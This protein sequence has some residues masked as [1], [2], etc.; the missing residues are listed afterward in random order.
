MKTSFQKVKKASP[1]VCALVI[2][3]LTIFGWGVIFEMAALWI[4]AWS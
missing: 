4:K 1:L 3:A 2:L